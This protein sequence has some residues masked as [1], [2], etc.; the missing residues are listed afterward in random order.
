MFKR[1]R[2][3]KEMLQINCSGAYKSTKNFMNNVL[4]R[5]K[6]VQNNITN[7]LNVKKLEY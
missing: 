7:F 6:P 2:S 5:K 3:F 4:F 1:D